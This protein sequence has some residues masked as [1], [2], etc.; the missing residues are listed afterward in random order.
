MKRA[1]KILK[2]KVDQNETAA[3]RADGVNR[4]DKSIPARQRG[5]KSI[6]ETADG[7]RRSTMENDAKT[8]DL[9]RLIT[10]WQGP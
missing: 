4:S 2:R 10:S 6:I 3:R 1:E 8:G 7:A 5:M 9:L